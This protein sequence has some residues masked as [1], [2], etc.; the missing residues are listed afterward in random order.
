MLELSLLF[1]V[2][3]ILQ[4]FLFLTK[5]AFV[6]RCVLRVYVFRKD[7][8]IYYSLEVSLPKG[9]TKYNV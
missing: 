1:L 5:R 8:F 7:L 3:L 2:K 4:L 6:R 9:S